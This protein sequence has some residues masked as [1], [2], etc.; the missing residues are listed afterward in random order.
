[1]TAILIILRNREIRIQV[2]LTKELS[3]FNYS[4]I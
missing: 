2:I 1:M 4:T 3:I